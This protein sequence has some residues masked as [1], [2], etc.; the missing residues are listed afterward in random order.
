MVYYAFYTPK[1]EVGSRLLLL[2]LRTC[3][4]N[5]L[6]LILRTS[7]VCVL[8]M[9]LYIFGMVGFVLLLT[10]T[11]AARYKPVSL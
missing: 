8:K 4:F 7:L 6:L 9:Y 2:C 11:S 3:R 5:L 10:I 1:Y